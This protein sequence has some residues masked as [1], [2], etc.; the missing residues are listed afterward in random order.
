MARAAGT[1]LPFIGPPPFTHAYAQHPA[2][3]LCARSNTPNASLIK[4]AQ[5]SYL[6]AS[7]LPVLAKQA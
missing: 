6:A 4:A 2:S 3:A 5:R 1:R 7:V